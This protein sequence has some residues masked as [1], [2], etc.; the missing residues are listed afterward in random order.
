MILEDYEILY[1][2]YVWESS[3][4]IL[5]WLRKEVEYEFE[6]TKWTY[7]EIQQTASL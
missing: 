3:N 6:T 4:G 2:R 5:K 7:P 1:E